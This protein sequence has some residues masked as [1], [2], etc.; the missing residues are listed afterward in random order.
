MYGLEAKSFA[1]N[2]SN[3]PTVFFKMANISVPAASSNPDPTK[4]TNW[5][6]ANQVM[7]FNG[8]NL[9]VQTDV[10]TSTSAGSTGYNIE[11]YVGTNLLYSRGKSCGNS[12][13]ASNYD[14]TNYALTVTGAPA[15]A[16]VLFHVGIDNYHNPVDLALLGMNGCEL[17]VKP[18]VV[19]SLNANGS[20]VATLVAPLTQPTTAFFGFVQASHPQAGANPANYVS[21]NMR[22]AMFGNAGISTYAYNWTTFTATAQYGPY[23]TTR[24]QIMLFR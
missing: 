6:P 16:P 14:R 8:P 23:S 19:A 20:G 21:T 11:G 13:L 9:I 4:P 17:Y 3:S 10:Q 2:L 7:V 24:G 5:I 12:S 18:L 15:N 22:S 1:G